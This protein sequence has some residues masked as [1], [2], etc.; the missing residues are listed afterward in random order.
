MRIN[1]RAPIIMILLTLGVALIATQLPL[2]T[3]MA[4]ARPT[5]YTMTVLFWVANQPRY[6]GLIAAWCAGLVIDIFYG[7]PFS[8]HALAMAVAAYS[9][10]KLR[11][12]YQDATLL[13]RPL[14]MLPAFIL[15]EFMLFWIDGVA[16][17]HTDLWWRWLPVI[18]STLLWPVWAFA[19]EQ[20][21]ET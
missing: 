14:L 10:I 2:P 15:Y 9:V 1:Q 6:M 18:S 13:T 3:S 8:E 12:L 11:M 21:A 7:T 19:L 16:G 20:V 5:F 17:L 4:A